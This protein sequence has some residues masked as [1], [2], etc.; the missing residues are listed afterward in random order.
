MIACAVYGAHSIASVEKRHASRTRLRGL[1]K[2]L[3]T[4]PIVASSHRK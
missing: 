3:R 2:T 4:S 1:E